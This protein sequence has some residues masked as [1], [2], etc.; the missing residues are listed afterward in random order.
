MNRLP[1]LFIGHGSPMNV[2][3]DNQWT[4]AWQQLGKTLP[5][6]QAILMISAHWYGRGSFV[7]SARQPKT[8]HDF[9][10]FPEALYQIQYPAPGSPELALRVQAVL[11]DTVTVVLDESYG[12][13]HG[14]WSVLY[15]LFPEADIPVVQLSMDATHH[16]QKHFDVGKQLATLREQGV[17]IIGSGNVVHNL[18]RYDWGRSQSNTTTW[19]HEFENTV[20]QLIQRNQ[21]EAL[22]HYQNLG[23]AA[24]LSIPTAE[25]YLPLLYVLGSAHENDPVS[26]PV[27]GIEGGSL[28]MLSVQL[29]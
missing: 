8:I 11:K 25:H 7:C 24:H 29:G 15:H 19:A 27:E 26:F 9:G 13:D 5:R 14:A 23:E 1:A 20:K 10:G 16:A 17:L 28:S 22:I 18:A 3:E 12:L 2:I 4:Q 21:V 6:P